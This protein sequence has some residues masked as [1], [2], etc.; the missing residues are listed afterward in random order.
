LA[1]FMAGADCFFGRTVE[2]LATTGWRMSDNARLVS[3]QEDQRDRR[4][5]IIFTQVKR[6]RFF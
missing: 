6:S 4:P 2:N 5:N 3:N 1:V